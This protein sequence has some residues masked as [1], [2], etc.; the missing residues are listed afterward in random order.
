MGRIGNP[1]PFLL[2][3]DHRHQVC[4][5]LGKVSDHALDVMNVALLFLHFELLEAD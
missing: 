1:G 5:F 3:G 4:F 2:V